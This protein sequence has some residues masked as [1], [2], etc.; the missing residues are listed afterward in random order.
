[1]VM[2][3]G[4]CESAARCSG[5]PSSHR[6]AYLH[7]WHWKERPAFPKQRVDVYKNMRQT[8]VSP[9]WLLYQSQEGRREKCQNVA[10]LLLLGQSS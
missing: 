4:V 2:I 5:P 8:N 7:V 6:E 3:T 10:G 9:L 1:M